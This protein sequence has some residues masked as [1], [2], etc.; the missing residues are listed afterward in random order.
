MAGEYGAYGRRRRAPT[1]TRSYTQLFVCSLVS[2]QAGSDEW[3][4][5]VTRSYLHPILHTAPTHS[6]LHI[7]S[8]TPAT[9]GWWGLWVE[10]R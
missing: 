3:L 2:S 1:S 6:L 5:R 7:R 4:R 10:E 8:F 9:C